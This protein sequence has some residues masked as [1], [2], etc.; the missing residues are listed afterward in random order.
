LL[1]SA[2]RKVGFNNSAMRPGSSITLDRAPVSP[3]TAATNP[4]ANV[5]VTAANQIVAIPP[6]E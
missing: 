3:R 5:L 4:P 2:A 1:L 6:H